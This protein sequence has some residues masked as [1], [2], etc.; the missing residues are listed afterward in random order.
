MLEKDTWENI[1]EVDQTRKFVLKIQDKYDML[2]QIQR[3]IQH[4]TDFL[5][6]NQSKMN[7]DQIEAMWQSFA[8]P[9]E[10]MLVQS[11]CLERLDNHATK[12]AEE[13]KTMQDDLAKK[14]LQI[15]KEFEDIQSQEELVNFE[16]VYRKCEET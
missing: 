8:K 12:Y 4:K 13:L 15:S 3:D 11:D 2:K 9:Q 14:I 10:I 16:L 7:K 6:A 1:E 5:D